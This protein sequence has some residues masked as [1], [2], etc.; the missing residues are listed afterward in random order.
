MTMIQLKLKIMRQIV[1]HCRFKNLW[2]IIGKRYRLLIFNKVVVIFLINMN[3]YHILPW[4]GKCCCD[5]LT[6]KMYL[7]RDTKI[8]AYPLIL[9]LSVSW[10]SI[11][12]EEDDSDNSTNN[13]S[14]AVFLFTFAFQLLCFSLHF[15]KY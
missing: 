15:I 5:T 6:S 11:D 1:M 3:D 9:K 14:I 4:F 7:S 8:V 2:A 10:K 13:Y 12:S